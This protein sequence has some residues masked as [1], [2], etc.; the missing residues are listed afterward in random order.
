MKLDIESV[1][2]GIISGVVLIVLIFF[3]I[4]P[5]DEIAGPQG[6]IITSLEPVIVHSGRTV[7]YVDYILDGEVQPSV[8]CSTEALA[9]RLISYLQEYRAAEWR[10]E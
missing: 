9:K 2:I 10:E 6:I 8:I 7:W 1:I 4:N 5:Q 3:A